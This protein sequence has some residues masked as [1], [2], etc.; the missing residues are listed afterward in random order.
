MDKT[1]MVSIKGKEQV[2]QVTGFS[3]SYRKHTA[4]RELNLEINRGEI[5][6]IIGP[7]GSGKSSLMKAVAGV[8]TFDAGEIEV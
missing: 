8:L 7:D 1:E 5:Y 4:V 3:K 6:G 2:V